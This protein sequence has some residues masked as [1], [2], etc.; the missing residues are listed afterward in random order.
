MPLL[1]EC[2]RAPKR[3]VSQKN[4][5]L[6][7]IAGL[8]LV[9]VAASA[10][11]TRSEVTSGGQVPVTNLQRR[12]KHRAYFG[13]SCKFCVC[14]GVGRDGLTFE[15]YVSLGLCQTTRFRIFNAFPDVPVVTIVKQIHRQSSVDDSPQ[16][17]DRSGPATTLVHHKERFK[18]SRETKPRFPA[19]RNRISPHCF[20]ASE[21][22]NCMNTVR[23]W[24]AEFNL[25]LSHERA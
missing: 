3:S 23:E 15:P 11:W 4:P 12:L 13:V 6:I 5:A 25:C 18:L 1:R 22:R 24:T 8:S 10:E 17:G 7:G 2:D 20:L 21:G 16:N 19:K 9:T 14:G